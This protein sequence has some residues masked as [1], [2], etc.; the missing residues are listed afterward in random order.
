VVYG[1][2]DDEWT[3]F[4]PDAPQDPKP[5]PPKKSLGPA[6]DTDT[7]AARLN[8]KRKSRPEGLDFKN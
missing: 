7:Q 5:E 6:G 1:Y 3:R 8:S 4:D 2:T